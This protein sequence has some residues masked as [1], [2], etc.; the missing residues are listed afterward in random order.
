[1]TAH[2]HPIKRLRTTTAIATLLGAAMI[3]LAPQADATVLIQFPPP[4]PA[5]ALRSST[6][7]T[8]S[9]FGTYINPTGTAPFATAPFVLSFQLPSE[10]QVGVGNGSFSLSGITGS[11]SNNGSI[12]DFSGATVDVAN[13][14]NFS[15]SQIDLLATPF[16]AS[17]GSF[18]LQVL[19]SPHLFSYDSTAGVATMT[20]GT[21][22]LD[23]G[24][25]S[26]MLDPGIGANANGVTVSQ[27]APES[28]AV[29][30]PGS[31]VLLGAGLLGLGLGMRK[32]HKS[33]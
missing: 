24:N 3:A 4:A 5:T 25:A 30:E 16:L 22:A 32:R 15:F 27:A 11:Y 14:T 1:M 6:V 9:I 12:T 26:Y 18:N 23:S 10:L 33:A 2:H 17:N 20:L 19:T 13:S 28:Q 31:L 21:F 7:D 8:V 29:P